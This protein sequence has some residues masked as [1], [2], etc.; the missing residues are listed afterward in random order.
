MKRARF[1]ILFSLTPFC[2]LVSVACLAQPNTL[3]ST[4]DQ[5]VHD[6]HLRS[7]NLI[8]ALVTVASR[9]RIPMGIQW[10]AESSLESNLTFSGED[11][12]VRHILSSIIETRPGYLLSTESGVVHI[13]STTI[14][15]NQNFLFLPIGSFKVHHE[16]V[17]LAERRLQLLARSKLA[18]PNA[19]GA[20]RGGSV[21][22]NVGEPKVDVV[23][24]EANVEDVLDALALASDKKIWIVTFSPNSDLTPTGFRRT[25]SLWSSGSVPDEKQPVWDIFRWDERVPLGEANSKGANSSDFR[26]I[27]RVEA[28]TGHH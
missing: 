1:L 25:V 14:P 3:E 11:T 7:D 16:P 12:T 8:E 10:V 6:Y 26:G 17:R 19:T 21:A 28:K 18:P 5:H 4:L 22:G 24:E 13:S 27:S 9:F 20:G 15:K 23:L 2:I